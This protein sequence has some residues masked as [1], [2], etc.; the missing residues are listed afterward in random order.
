MVTNMLG[1]TQ[2]WGEGI[3]G[4][5]DDGAEVQL[6]RISAMLEP[7]NTRE[8]QRIRN[9]E[10]ALRGEALDRRMVNL[11]QTAVQGYL[12]NLKKTDP[13]AYENLVSVSNRLL[14]PTATERFIVEQGSAWD[15][16]YLGI[17]DG[18]REDLGRPIDFA[19]QSDRE[20]IGNAVASYIRQNG[21]PE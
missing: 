7:I 12:D 18:V 9:G 11:E 3:F 21:M 2:G 8:F 16:I 5:V 10:V 15:T 19:R 13:K 4:G 6:E 17:L 14:S 1:T 20:V